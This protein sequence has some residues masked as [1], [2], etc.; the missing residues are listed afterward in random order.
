M[1]KSYLAL[2][3][4][5]LPIML[6]LF[7]PIGADEGTQTRPDFVRLSGHIPSRAVSRAQALGTLDA[8]THVPVTFTLPLRNQE[9]LQKFINRLYDPSDALYGKY[10]TSYRIC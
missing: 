6:A 8:Q 9:D 1:T 10:L 5:S 2:L 3:K 4:G 7:T